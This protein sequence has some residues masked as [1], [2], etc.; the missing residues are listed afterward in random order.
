MIRKNVYILLGFVQKMERIYFVL[1]LI[2]K[3]FNLNFLRLRSLNKTFSLKKNTIFLGR[4][5]DIDK[6]YHSQKTLNHSSL[7]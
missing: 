4:V 2:L 7:P 3:S 5:I 6:M 1:Q